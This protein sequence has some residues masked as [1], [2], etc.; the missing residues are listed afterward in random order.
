MSKS[1]FEQEMAG[2]GTAR[3]RVRRERLLKA[4]EEARREIDAQAEADGS[5]R[6]R[7]QGHGYGAG[8]GA[9]LPTEL[10]VGFAGLRTFPGQRRAIA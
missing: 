2:G 1:S 10:R 5:G 6:V 4:I 7:R 9:H 8:P 3:G